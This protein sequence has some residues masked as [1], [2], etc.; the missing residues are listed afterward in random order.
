MVMTAIVSPGV[1][2]SGRP[3]QGQRGYYDAQLAQ[4]TRMSSLR[5][6]WEDIY[7]KAT[8]DLLHDIMN[9]LKN[10]YVVGILGICAG[11]MIGYKLKK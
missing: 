11:I 9:M 7:K 8:N 1:G 3:G 2:G 4:R 10:P 5:H 6:T